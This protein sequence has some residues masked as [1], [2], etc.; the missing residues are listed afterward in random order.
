MTV[1]SEPKK[2]GRKAKKT[3]DN[4]TPTAPK[5]GRKPKGGKIIENT[6][7]T[8]VEPPQKPN[9]IVHLKC[10]SK[11][12]NLSLDHEFIQKIIIIMVEFNPTILILTKTM[13]YNIN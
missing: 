5:K 12:I 9:V 6:K 11:D 3:T 10:N 8:I 7:I 2:R 4:S 1:K 13:T